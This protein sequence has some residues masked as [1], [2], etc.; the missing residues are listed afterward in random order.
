[1]EEVFC[2]LEVFGT[3]VSISPNQIN[4]DA[5]WFVRSRPYERCIYNLPL[6]C[7]FCHLFVVDVAMNT[8]E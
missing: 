3:P 5:N 6:F 1:M 2:T 7:F 4:M 8:I